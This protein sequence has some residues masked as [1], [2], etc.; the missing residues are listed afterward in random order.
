MGGDADETRY[1]PLA[2]PKYSHNWMH[3]LASMDLPTKRGTRLVKCESGLD[4]TVVPLRM[5]NL[6]RHDKKLNNVVPIKPNL[7]HVK[8]RNVIPTSSYTTTKMGDDGVAYVESNLQWLRYVHATTADHE[9]TDD[10][11]RRMEEILV[12]VGSVKVEEPSQEVR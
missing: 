3:L 12:S 6:V 9:F 4:S 7:Q 11:G 2:K 8:Q 10:M 5:I 1:T